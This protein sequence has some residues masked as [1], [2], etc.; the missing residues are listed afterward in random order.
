[1]LHELHTQKG[2]QLETFVCRGICLSQ[3]ERARA[4]HEVTMCWCAFTVVKIVQRLCRYWWI[5][6]AEL[7]NLSVW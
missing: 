3:L 6:G 5:L 2:V 7:R 4:A 1:M